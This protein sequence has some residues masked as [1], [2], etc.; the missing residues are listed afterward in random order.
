MGLL[1]SARVARETAAFLKTGKFL[2]RG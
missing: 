2:L 1:L